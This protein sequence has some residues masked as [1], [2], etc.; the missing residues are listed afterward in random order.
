[1]QDPEFAEEYNLTKP[2]FDFALALTMAREARNL[3]QVQLSE[4]TGIKQPMISRYE[5]GQIPELPTLRKLAAA[6]NARIIIE[7][8]GRT[9][10]TL[11]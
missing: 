5:R 3:T 7:P 6:L 9:A 8:N 2:E 1:M 10:I 4:A 11:A